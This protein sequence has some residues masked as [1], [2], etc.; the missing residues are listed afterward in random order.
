[1]TRAVVATPPVVIC[2]RIA[3]LSIL[4]LASWDGPSLKE[5]CR[6]QRTGGRAKENDK[7]KEQ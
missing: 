3:S 5:V 7:I 6:S 1:M 4:P 2:P